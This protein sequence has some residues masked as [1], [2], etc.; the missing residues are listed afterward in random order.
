[1]RSAPA[2]RGCAF[3]LVE[4]LVVVA[5]IAILIGLLLPAVQKVREAANTSKCGS[6]LRQVVLAVHSFHEMHAQMPPYNGVFPGLGKSLSGSWFAH[7]QPFIGESAMHQSMMDGSSVTSSQTVSTGTNCQTVTVT[8]PATDGSDITY[9]GWTYSTPGNG[10][11]T[12]TTT[13]CDTTTSNVT[14]VVYG[15]NIPPAPKYAYPIL[16][17][18]GDPTVRPNQLDLWDSWTTTSYVPNWHAWTDRKQ[19][20]N[21]DPYNRPAMKFDAISDGLSV[22]V[23]FTDAYANCDRWSRRALVSPEMWGYIDSYR[24]SNV[25]LFQI[26]PCDG[27]GA[28]CC[29]NIRVQ[30]GHSVLNAAMGDGSVRGLAM[31]TPTTWA[32]ILRPT[33][34]VAPGTDF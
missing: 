23:F 4:L 3:T 13:V 27:T 12:Y 8:V 22:T 32:A 11:Y 26:R 17:C 25:D 24:H 34:R 31:M 21:Y 20:P 9:N 1:M 30:S 33:D 7:L 14:N 19:A 10:S 5:I 2:R 15:V 6:N 16:R 29:I 28:D 18:P